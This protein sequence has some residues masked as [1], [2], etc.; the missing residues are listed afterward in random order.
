[1]TAPLG[2]KVPEIV[3]A[4]RDI[5]GPLTGGDPMGDTKFVRPSLQAL[6]TVLGQQGLSA[7]PTTVARLLRDLDYSPRINVKRFTGPDHPDRDRQFRNIEEWI[8]I[9]EDLGQPI[10][11]VDAKKKEQVTVGIRPAP[12]AP[13]VSKAKKARWTSP[14]SS[15]TNRHS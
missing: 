3:P 15:A 13:I 14:A 2:K 9:F 4:L 7:C 11:S 6:S 12:T 5:V 8:A 1:M 10:I